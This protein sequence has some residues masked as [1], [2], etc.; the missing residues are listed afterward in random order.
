METKA[1][2]QRRS[3][4]KVAGAAASVRAN[5]IR[6]RKIAAGDGWAPWRKT[7]GQQQAL[8]PAR[9]FPKA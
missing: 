2:A 3:R 9:G 7:D 6:T 1:E 4:L 8:R 5:N